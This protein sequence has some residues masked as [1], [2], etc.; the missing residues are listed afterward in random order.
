MPVSGPF[1][2]LD[3]SFSQACGLTASGD[4]ECFVTSDFID[5]DPPTNG[6]YTDLTV[7]SSSI[8]G[9]GTDQLLD[10][11]FRT[12]SPSDLATAAEEFPLDVPFSSIERSNIQFGGI[13]ICGVRAE[14]GT[15]S[16]FGFAGNGFG[17]ELPP[18]PGADAIA[19]TLTAANISLS[20]TAE[21]YGPNQVE[22]FWNRV[23]S[24]LPPISVEV[25]RDDE[26]LT[27]T[28]NQF[29]FFDNDI[30]VTAEESSYRIRTVDEAGN[31]GEFSNVIVVNRATREVNILDDESGVDN[32]RPGSPFSIQQLSVSTFILL[33]T[34]NDSFILSWSIDNPTNVDVAGF[35]VR[36]DN[37]PVAFVN[38]T[39]F[40]GDGVV[41][42]DCRIYSVAAIAN[43]GAVLDY[44]SVSFGT[45]NFPC[46][47]VP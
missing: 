46:Q 39:T 42:G 37:E 14:N 43:D 38:N 11:S 41:F 36:I 47:S 31:M 8:C 24:V 7:T 23:P 16:C 12:F 4:I 13:P 30:S 15:I 5:L 3:L 33:F 10:C 25:F 34:N 1:V 6:P 26:L 29:S 2:D 40:I 32:P 35:E 27:T 44:A 20:L 28:S 21:I 19:N 9:L 45:S 17:G 22:L 18:P